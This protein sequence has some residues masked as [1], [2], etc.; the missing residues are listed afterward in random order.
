MASCS[1]CTRRPR[2]TRRCRPANRG[3]GRR[4][5][6]SLAPVIGD[7]R[8][9]LAALT[10]RPPRPAGGCGAPCRSAMACRQP[11]A[12]A[13]LHLAHRGIQRIRVEGGEQPTN[14]ASRGVKIASPAR[15]PAGVR[16]SRVLSDVAQRTLPP[17]TRATPPRHHPDRTSGAWPPTP[18]CSPAPAPPPRPRIPERRAAQYPTRD[19]PGQQTAAGRERQYPP[20]RPRL[21]IHVREQH[22]R[23]VEAQRA[24]AVAGDDHVIVTLDDLLRIGTPCVP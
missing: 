24:I 14:A 19:E 4:R 5:T 21:E 3:S 2:S 9:A 22:V 16:Y 11:C 12:E 7:P 17:A 13:M 15:R 6:G 10:A 18:A 1:S 23:R 8:Q 20:R